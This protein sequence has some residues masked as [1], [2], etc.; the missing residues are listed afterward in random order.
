MVIFDTPIA[1]CG[2]P[3]IAVPGPEK[4]EYF[5]IEHALGIYFEPRFYLFN[6]LGKHIYVYD[7]ATCS[8]LPQRPLDHSFSVNPS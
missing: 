7:A 3:V 8:A 1:T 6:R 5:D 4:S 2:T